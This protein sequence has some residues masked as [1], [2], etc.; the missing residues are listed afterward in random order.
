MPKKIFF[1]NSHPIQYFAPLYQEI[2]NNKNFE[3]TVL[4]GTVATTQGTIDKQFGV[5]VKWDIPLLEGYHYRV[6]KNYSFNKKFSSGFWQLINPGLILYLLQ[7]PKSVVIV[8]GWGY[9]THILAIIFSKLKGHIVCIRAETPLNQ[10]LRKNKLITFLKHLWLRFLFLFID[11]FLYIGSENKKFYQY[12][13]IKEYQLIFTPYAVDNR[14]FQQFSNQLSKHYAKQYLQLPVQDKIILYSGKYISKKRPL[15]LLKAFN[16][17]AANNTVHLVMVGDGELKP[18]MQAFITNNNLQTKVTLTGFI[19]Q[20]L[21]P[22]YYKAADVFVMCSGVG[23]T[24][25]LSTNEAMNFGMPVIISSTC[26]AAHNLIQGNGWIFDEGNITALTNCLQEFINKPDKELEEMGQKS[27]RIINTYS[28]SAI[29]NG[30]AK[31]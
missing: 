26:G 16:N 25:G 20:S 3:L 21:I 11:K 2:A 29:I 23:E 12:L 13:G 28:Y 9:C 19:N 31:I 4:Y 22:Y 24:W 30:L 10:E 14:R 18:Q 7:Q 15:D 1:I 5:K 27:L 6:F 17:I 8:H